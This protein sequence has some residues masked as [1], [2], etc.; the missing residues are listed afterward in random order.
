[1]LVQIRHRK[2]STTSNGVDALDKCNHLAKARI[3]LGSVLQ[4]LTNGRNQKVKKCAECLA[5]EGDRLS[6]LTIVSNLR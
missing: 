3:E 5:A 4:A 1:M 6:L 2:P